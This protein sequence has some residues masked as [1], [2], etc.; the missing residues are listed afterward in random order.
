MPAEEKPHR[1]SN[2]VKHLVECYKAVLKKERKVINFAHYRSLLYLLGG[3]LTLAVIIIIIYL[4]K[5]GNFI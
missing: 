1:A 3:L 5:Y 4:K 2:G